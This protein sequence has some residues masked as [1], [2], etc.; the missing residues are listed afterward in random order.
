[1]SGLTHTF[2][3][4]NT[5]EFN[6][7]RHS[8]FI[9]NPHGVMVHD[10]LLHYVLD[11]LKWIPAYNPNKRESCRG[12]CMDGETVIKSNGAII[13]AG[14]FRAWADLFAI[15]PEFLKLRGLWTQK[16]GESN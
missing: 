4:V 8:S 1:M 10:E 5:D 13:A 3:L 9:N 14:I 2:F 15:G 11:T 16:E 12:L 6:Y 7:C